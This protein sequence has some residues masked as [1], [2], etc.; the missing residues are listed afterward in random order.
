MGATTT[1][2]SSVSLLSM[3]NDA[4]IRCPALWGVMAIA[5]LCVFGSLT[6]MVCAYLMVWMGASLVW[7]VVTVLMEESSFVASAA[8]LLLLFLL[9]D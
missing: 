7:L 5:G 9:L 6:M 4:P 8:A 3:K 1:S 2:V